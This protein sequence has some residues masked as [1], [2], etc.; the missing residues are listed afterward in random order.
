MGAQSPMAADVTGAAT[1]AEY[2]SV[3]YHGLARTAAH[4]A[5]SLQ[6]GSVLGEETLS[7]ASF[8]DLGGPAITCASEQ[9]W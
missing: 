9:A 6:H 3:S 5:D 2:R 1:G 4:S 7:D 8:R